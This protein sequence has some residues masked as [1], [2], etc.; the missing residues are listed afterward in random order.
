MSLQRA[1]NQNCYV[2]KA[3]VDITLAMRDVTTGIS[4][5]DRDPEATMSPAPT[6]TRPDFRFPEP[7]APLRN[8]MLERALNDLSAAFEGIAR[9]PGGDLGGARTAANGRIALVARELIAGINGSNEA[10]RAGR[11]GPFVRS[12]CSNP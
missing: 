9:S 8:M 4:F 1:A 7:P 6:V 2:Q 5:L 10:Y 11:R 12:P 3:V